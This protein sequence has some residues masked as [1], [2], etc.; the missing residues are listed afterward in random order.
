MV[1]I[2]L[3]VSESWWN[4]AIANFGPI[5]ASRD[6]IDAPLFVKREP[7]FGVA[8]PS[9]LMCQGFTLVELMI[10]VAVL[11][12]VS[13]IAIPAYQGYIEDARTGTML[14]S[15]ETIRVFQENRRLEQGE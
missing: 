3:Q 13:A 6:A 11:G 5:G 4:Y 1:S 7:L 2:I 9:R 14:Q 10:V 12:I 8:E 15:I